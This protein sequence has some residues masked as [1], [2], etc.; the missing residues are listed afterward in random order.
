MTVMKADKKKDN[1]TDVV[2]EVSSQPTDGP[3]SVGEGKVSAG[4]GEVV[5]LG[6]DAEMQ[7]DIDRVAKLI[8]NQIKK[9]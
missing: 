9:K 5:T 1:L 7:K 4:D 6:I 2:E 3:S 8:T